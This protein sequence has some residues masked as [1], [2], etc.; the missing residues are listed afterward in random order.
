MAVRDVTGR[1][2][3]PKERGSRGQEILMRGTNM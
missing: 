3:R 1:S 2:Q